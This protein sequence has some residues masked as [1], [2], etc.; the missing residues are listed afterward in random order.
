MFFKKKKISLIN[1]AKPFVFD[2]RTLR[3]QK[4]I[5]PKKIAMIIFAYII[6]LFVLFGVFIWNL[7]YASKI[8]LYTNGS[9]VSVQMH[10]RDI[11]K[12][13]FSLRFLV[14]DDFNT[15]ANLQNTVWSSI[16]I[17]LVGVALSTAG[18]ITQTLTRN[19]LADP[20]TLG[21]VSAT[22]FMVVLAI[23]FDFRM[24]QQKIGFA[25][26]GGGVAALMLLGMVFMSKQK[27]SFLKM[28]LAGLATGVF[29][30]TVS[31][32]I[33]SSEESASSANML[34]ILGGPENILKA[35]G[36]ADFKLLWICAVTIVIGFVVSMLISHKLSLLDLGDEKAKNLGSSVVYIKMIA[37][38]ATILLI[39]PS[40][41]LA[42]N[43]AFVGLFTPH[44]VRK[45]FGVRDYRI[46]IPLS[47]S[48]GALI[49]ALG[50]ILTREIPSINSSIWMHFI[51]APTLA[52]VGWVN[53]KNA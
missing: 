1:T 29:F 34:Y 18:C 26:I 33:R 40:I 37:I 7:S 20:S 53:W 38:L 28:T 10:L 45:V 17:M 16:A 43:V 24:Y 15:Y 31:Y 47:A 4:L 22:V 21:I 48:V 35:N 50:L 25:F 2:S 30:N 41:L 13:V 32:F 5:S 9:P 12:L 27:K 44:I 23:S 8:D 46:V 6:L 3:Y 51:G 42:G 39:A 11:L 19:P 49:T 36:F 14:I 52:Y